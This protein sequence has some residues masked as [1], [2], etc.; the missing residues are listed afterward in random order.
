VEQVLDR[1]RA[2][3][4]AEEEPPYHFVEVMACPGGCIGGGGQSWGITDEIRRQRA[5]G[6]ADDDRRS[7]VRCSHANPAVKQIYAEF[8]EQPLSEA[9]HRLLHTR[10][11]PRPEYQR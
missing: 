2:A 11:E 6:L 9:A 10:Y 3:K 7:D 1:I 4:D 8:L 5:A